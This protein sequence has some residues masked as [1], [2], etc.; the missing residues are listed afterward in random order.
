MSSIQDNIR[1]EFGRICGAVISGLGDPV[2]KFLFVQQN[3]KFV[4][5][6]EILAGIPC[7]ALIRNDLT[8]LANDGYCKLNMNDTVIEIRYGEIMREVAS[9]NEHDQYSTAYIY[10]EVV[11]SPNLNRRFKLFLLKLIRHL[12]PDDDSVV[13]RLHMIQIEHDFAYFK[14]MT[15]AVVQ[16]EMGPVETA[17]LGGECDPK[18]MVKF[19]AELFVRVL[20]SGQKCDQLLDNV[21]SQF[22]VNNIRISSL[23][24]MFNAYLY[25][26]LNGFTNLMNGSGNA[27]RVRRIMTDVSEMNFDHLNYGEMCASIKE[28]LDTFRES[29]L[30]VFAELIQCMWDMINDAP[31]SK[32]AGVER[33]GNFWFSMQKLVQSGI[34]ENNVQEGSV[35]TRV[36]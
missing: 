21:F 1:V 8:A 35:I 10:H 18:T 30:D 16:G 15:A 12:R 28:G 25:E 3:L 14:T 34:V 24:R 2:G 36:S 26:R 13:E 17:A 9:P 5:P 27:D 6:N 29:K 31:N 32:T 20:R 23:L 4:D 22:A 33:F 11:S 19:V 7:E